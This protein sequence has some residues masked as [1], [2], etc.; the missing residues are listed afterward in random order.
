MCRAVARHE[1]RDVISG[2]SEAVS[3]AAVGDC[4]DLARPWRGLAKTNPN[5]IPD[6]VAAHA[7]D[8]LAMTL[9][10]VPRDDTTASQSSRKANTFGRKKNAFGD[11]MVQYTS[12]DQEAPNG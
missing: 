2:V 12:C 10:G 11:R 3:G 6:R 5:V 8:K 4:V 9:D 1:Q 7:M